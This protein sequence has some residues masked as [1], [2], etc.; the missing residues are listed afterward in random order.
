M[1]KNIQYMSHNFDIFLD[2]L[3]EKIATSSTYMLARKV[4]NLEVIGVKRLEEEA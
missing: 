3:N 1:S 4:A 2:R